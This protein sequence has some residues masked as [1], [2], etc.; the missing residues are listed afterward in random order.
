MGSTEEEEDEGEAEVLAARR[1]AGEEEGEEE[2]EE[3]DV[4]TSEE[5]VFLKRLKG[6][7]VSP[8]PP[9]PPP[10][11]PSL[12]GCM[13]IIVAALPL[14]AEEEGEEERSS[15]VEAFVVTLRSLVSKVEAEEG[16]IFLA[17]LSAVV[18]VVVLASEGEGESVF[19]DAAFVSSAFAADAAFTAF[20]FSRAVWGAGDDDPAAGEAADDEPEEDDGGVVVLAGDAAAGGSSAFAADAAFTAFNFSRAV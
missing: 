15:R 4:F 19:V 6:E 3:D 1:L 14:G 2:G 9:P 17:G 7:V 5:S 12:T 10:L 16:G 8:P 13:P 20:N 18:S 11:E